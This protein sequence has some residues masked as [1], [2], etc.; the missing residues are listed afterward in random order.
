MPDLLLRGMS[1]EL[2]GELGV[3][4]GAESQEPEFGDTGEAG[5]VGPGRAGGR[6]GAAGADTAAARGR[7]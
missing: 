2:H 4:G 6:R 5:G 7:R 1:G 3:G